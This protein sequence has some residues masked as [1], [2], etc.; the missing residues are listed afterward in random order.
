MGTSV[1]FEIA[2]GEGRWV[3]REDLTL[4]GE[5]LSEDGQ[6]PGNMG[7]CFDGIRLGSIGIWVFELKL[8]DH[9][10]E[11]RTGNASAYRVG[12]VLAGG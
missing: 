5:V 12:K 11:S 9:F 7:G 6:E 3:H 4:A 2:G 10:V 1:V 8:D